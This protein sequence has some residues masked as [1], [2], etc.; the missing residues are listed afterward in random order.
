MGSKSNGRLHGV[1]LSIAPVDVN[2]LNLK[3]LGRMI[4][5]LHEA[6]RRAICALG[7]G[8]SGE[9]TFTTFFF[10]SENARRVGGRPT[11]SS[12]RCYYY[13]EPRL[14]SGERIQRVALPSATGDNDNSSAISAGQ[15][16][17]FQETEMDERDVRPLTYMKQK[18]TILRQIEMP[19]AMKNSIFIASDCFLPSLVNRIYLNKRPIQSIPANH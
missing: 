4:L 12:R 10:F 11:S 9:T 13:C 3:K 14:Q 19:T 2:W 6:K 17:L 7:H 16:N 8:A 15:C 1:R 5:D 18:Q